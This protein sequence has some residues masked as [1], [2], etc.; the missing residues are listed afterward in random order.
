MTVPL[1]KTLKPVFQRAGLNRLWTLKSDGGLKDTVTHIALGRGLYAPNAEMAG[2]QNEFM[3]V[4]VL[5]TYPVNST[6]YAFYA[7]A[8]YNGSAVNEPVGEIAFLL[9]DGTPLAIYSSSMPEAYMTNAV[10]FRLTYSLVIDAVPA[11]SLT[12]TNTEIYFNL[13]VQRSIEDL[14]GGYAGLAADA[15]GLR[16]R[17]IAHDEEIVSAKSRLTQAEQKLS[18]ASIKLPA[19]SE[20]VNELADEVSR[21]SP[22][23]HDHEM[24]M[25]TE[26]RQKLSDIAEH[27]NN[28]AHPETHPPAIIAQDES[29][30]FV[31]DV[32]KTAWSNKADGNHEHSGYAMAIEQQEE[33]L[34]SVSALLMADSLLARSKAIATKAAIAQA[35]SAIATNGGKITQLQ[36]RS[37]QHKELATLELISNDP[38]SGTLMYRNQLVN[39]PTPPEIEMITP[40]SGFAIAMT[41]A[42][43]EETP[44]GGV[45][46]SDINTLRYS[47]NVP[48]ISLIPSEI[49]Y[50]WI[51]TPTDL[52]SPDRVHSVG[53]GVSF[54]EIGN[55]H[56]KLYC[57]AQNALGDKSKIITVRG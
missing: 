10:M 17:D 33:S 57:W 55:Q 30:R 23:N 56:K 18:Q 8:T 53:G 45:V 20:R 26:E 19:I 34:V 41:S 22:L 4:P 40:P 51:V 38:N 48:S 2:L 14:T 11:D 52:A 42:P 27:A 35:E 7:E 21:K 15:L 9:S 24:L 25:T 6:Q 36:Q 39:P 28:Y 5:D 50:H 3:R 31:T 1:P 13:G 32:E 46:Y 54:D 44:E 37:H 12:F 47:V 49:T 29:N 16:Q 43:P